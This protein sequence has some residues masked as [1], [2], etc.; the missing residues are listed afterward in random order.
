E[1]LREARA[2]AEFE[3]REREA[4]EEFER[5]KMEADEDI[6]NYREE[7][8]KIVDEEVKRETAERMARSAEELE[9]R[10]KVCGRLINQQEELRIQNIALATQLGETSA[11]L[12]LLKKKIKE[13][14][15]D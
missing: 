14:E 6:R 9:R 5:R 7:G 13:L 10:N 11:T 2:D 4:G 12:E 1:K 15:H 3:K 8:K